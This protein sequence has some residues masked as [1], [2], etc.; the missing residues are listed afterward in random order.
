MA[1]STSMLFGLAAIFLV[2]AIPGAKCWYSKDDKEYCY[3]CLEG[4]KPNP[5]QTHQ[6]CGGVPGSGFY[7]SCVTE[8][9]CKAGEYR[10]HGSCY[11]DFNYEDPCTELMQNTHGK[12]GKWKMNLNGI[13]NKENRD[14]KAQQGEIDNLIPGNEVETND[15]EVTKHE[16]AQRDGIIKKIEIE[17]ELDN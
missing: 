12:S 7:T 14:E 8:N 10:H 1:S 13:C 2:V 11:T 16:K 6:W 15:Q 3:P 9:G 4:W 17:L 5:L